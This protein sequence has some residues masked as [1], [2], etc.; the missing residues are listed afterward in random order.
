MKTRHGGTGAAHINWGM[1]GSR[2]PL[3]APVG[4]GGGGGGGGGGGDLAPTPTADDITKMVNEVVHKAFGEREK[5]M[6]KTMEKTM[7]DFMTKFQESLPEMLKEH[8]PTPPDPGQPG[9]PKPQPGAL[10]P[11]L[12]A[13]FKAQENAI[14]VATEKAA[15]M[16]K[17][18]DEERTARARTEEK[19]L[20]LQELTGKVKP[21]V[22]EMVVRDLHGSNITRDPESGAIL[23]KNGDEVLPL[24]DGVAAWAKSDLGKEFAP[25]VNAGGGGRTPGNGPM[26][27]NGAALTPEDV[28]NLLFGGGSR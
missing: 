9:Q 13:R 7:S 12:E 28:G 15:K 24:K 26:S 14:K 16:E 4:D 3:L 18:R 19:Q 22:L 25:P 21:T 8:A 23:W 5:R 6:V 27:P 11:E 1:F 20:L 10:S 2:G 17:E